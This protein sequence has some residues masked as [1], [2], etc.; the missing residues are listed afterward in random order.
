MQEF[1]WHRVNETMERAWGDQ[2]EAAP[3]FPFVLVRAGIQL[4]QLAENLLG[5]LKWLRPAYKEYIM[6]VYGEELL[7]ANQ[8]VKQNHQ[9]VKLACRRWCITN[10]IAGISSLL[11]HSNRAHCTHNLQ[12]LGRKACRMWQ[13]HNTLHLLLTHSWL[14]EKKLLQ[15][16]SESKESILI[17]MWLRGCWVRIPF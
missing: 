7:T 13:P 11:L 8:R 2:M 4:E 14:Q 15:A 17:A 1:A 5:D 12:Y 3:H 6:H 16:A 9:P 10:Y